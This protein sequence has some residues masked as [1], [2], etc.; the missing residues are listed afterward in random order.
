MYFYSVL[1]LSINDLGLY[2]NKFKYKNTNDN[3]RG[4]KNGTLLSR[5]T[6]LREYFQRVCL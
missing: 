6:F 3:V 5:N 2:D 4:F 1:N